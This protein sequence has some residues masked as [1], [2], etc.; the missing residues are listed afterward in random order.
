MAGAA[1]FRCLVTTLVLQIKFLQFLVADFDPALIGLQR[2]HDEFDLDPLRHHK[3]ALVIRVVFFG[4][5]IGDFHL[6]AVLGRTEQDLADFPLL[7]ADF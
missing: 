5:G 2:K 4:V 6:L 3:I 7:L 1:F